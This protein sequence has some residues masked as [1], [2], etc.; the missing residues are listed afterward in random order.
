MPSDCLENSYPTPVTLW[1]FTL[2]TDQN[3]LSWILNL[4]GASGPLGRWLL[5]SAQY[6][7]DVEYR[8]GLKHQLADVVSRLISEGEDGM[9]MD[10]E[11]PCFIIE[12]NADPKM[13]QKTVY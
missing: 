11:I 5:C 9:E 10:Y 4:E 2:R 8:P 12:S 3:N 1:W 7:Y 13:P 6:E